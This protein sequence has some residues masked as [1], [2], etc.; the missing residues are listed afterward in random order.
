[1]LEITPWLLSMVQHSD[2]EYSR[3]ADLTEDNVALVLKPEIAGSQR[4]D[5]TAHGGKSAQQ[6]KDPV[7]VQDVALSP[8][9]TPG[10][11]RPSSDFL[12]ISIRGRREGVASHLSW[13]LIPASRL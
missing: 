6:I 3:L 10:A 1:M 2:D 9:D 11:D 5:V 13:K 12:Y 7:Q 8:F 4:A